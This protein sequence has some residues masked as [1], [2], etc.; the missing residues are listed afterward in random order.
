MGKPA[1]SDIGI[2]CRQSQPRSGS[3]RWMCPDLRSKRAA[4]IVLMHCWMATFLRFLRHT[5]DM[6][7]A[8]DAAAA[9]RHLART[10][11]TARV[12]RLRGLAF[13]VL[14]CLCLPGM[15]PQGDDAD[16]LRSASWEA[17]VQ[18]SV[19]ASLR[20][21]AA[22]CRS[23]WLQAAQKSMQSLKGEDRSLTRAFSA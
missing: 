6:L 11:G 9:D 1:L 7:L 13:Y 20:F 5:V 19:P 4:S 15:L 18:I 14:Q 12:E 16:P 10:C 8:G 3:P 22:L 21:V 2:Q 17:R 23:S